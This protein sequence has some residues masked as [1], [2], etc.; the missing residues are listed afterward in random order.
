MVG[1]A[2]R[3]SATLGD[4]LA[5]VARHDR[6]VDENCEIGVSVDSA[7]ARIVLRPLAP[8]EW[9]RAYAEFLSAALLELMRASS[10]VRFA[11]AAVGFAHGAPSAIANH[12]EYFGCEPAF[13]ARENFMVVPAALLAQRLVH[14]DAVQCRYFDARLE[15]LCRSFGEAPGPLAEVRATALSLLSQGT[16]TIAAIGSRLGVSRRT[17]QRRLNERGVTFADLLDSARREA[18]LKAIARRDVSVEELALSSGFT[19]VKAFRRAF[20]RW[21]GQSP[22]QYR[23]SLG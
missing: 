14:S 13:G 3:A 18:A 5:R 20:T 22:S 19:D 1:L 23:K 15:E 4:A 8:L 6:L 12:T 10:G 16:P 9:P 11:A 7:G 2:A 17:L 21:T